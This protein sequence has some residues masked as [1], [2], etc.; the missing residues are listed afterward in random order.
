MIIAT[1]SGLAARTMWRTAVRRKPCEPGKDVR[2]Q[3]D[4]RREAELEVGPAETSL[5]RSDRPTKRYSHRSRSKHVVHV[6][7]A[8]SRDHV[9]ALDGVVVA[10]GAAGDVLEARRAAEA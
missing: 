10:V 4:R 5:R 9:I 8:D 1:L 7:T 2:H 3:P 6:G